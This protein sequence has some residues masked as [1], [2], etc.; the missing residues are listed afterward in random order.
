MK[1]LFYWMIFQV[2]VG[3]WLINSPY[4]LGYKEIT[5][6]TLDNLVFGAVVVILGIGAAF[7]SYQTLKHNE[8]KRT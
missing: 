4:A 1:Y 5:S 3:L 7:A 6:V 8:E 2:L